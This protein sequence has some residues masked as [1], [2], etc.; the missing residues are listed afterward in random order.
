MKVRFL[1]LLLAA[2]V[3]ASAQGGIDFTPA[4]G[5][6]ELAGIK[7]PQ[8]YF[9]DNGRTVIYEH[10]RGWSYSGGGPRI[11]FTPPELTQAFAEIDQVPLTA[12][13]NFDEP[14]VKALRAKTLSLVPPDS[15][16]VV[17]VS[18]QPDP[19]LVNNNHSYEFIV[20]YNAFGQEFMMGVVYVNLP[21]TQLRFRTTA[22]KPN[23]QTMHDAFRGSI[24]SWQWK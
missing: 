13:Q 6:R 19:V 9:K 5:E 2:G 15:Q 16:S 24:F 17:I 1:T 4:V 14:T 22:R 20:S 12:P 8:L 10:P 11:K 18:E 21:D 23:F 3:S 7:F